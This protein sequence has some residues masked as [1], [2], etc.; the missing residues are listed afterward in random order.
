MGR[1]LT[2]QVNFS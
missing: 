2:V 1:A